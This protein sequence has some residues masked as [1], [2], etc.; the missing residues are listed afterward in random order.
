MSANA[1]ICVRV[2]ILQRCAGEETVYWLLILPGGKCFRIV[3]MRMSLRIPTSHT[4]QRTLVFKGL[5]EQEVYLQE[6]S[7]TSNRSGVSFYFFA[8]DHLVVDFFCRLSSETEN[9]I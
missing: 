7:R 2:V 8:A 4:V 6:C 5:K 1:F 9:G 3:S